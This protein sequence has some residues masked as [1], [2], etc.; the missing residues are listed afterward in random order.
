L[1]WVAALSYFIPILST[2]ISVLYLG[3]ATGPRVW[4]GCALVAAGSV[5]CKY[6]VI[7]RKAD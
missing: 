6:S 7:E 3:I 2:L 4:I 1:V 5:I